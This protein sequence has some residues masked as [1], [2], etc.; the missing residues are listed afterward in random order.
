MRKIQIHFLDLIGSEFGS[1]D[2]DT[3]SIAKCIIR[4]RALLEKFI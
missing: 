2:L 4:R 1:P 3:E